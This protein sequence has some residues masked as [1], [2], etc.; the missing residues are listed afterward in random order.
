MSPEFYQ[1]QIGKNQLRADVPDG[2][3]LIANSLRYNNVL[4]LTQLPHLIALYQQ[5]EKTKSMGAK[6]Q[7]KHIRQ[8]IQI[9]R[10]SETPPLIVSQSFLAMVRYGLSVRK[11]DPGEFV[12]NYRQSAPTLNELNTWNLTYYD[13]QKAKEAPPILAGTVVPIHLD[14]IDEN[15]VWLRPVTDGPYKG[16]WTVGGGHYDNL[17]EVAGFE[18]LREET[19]DSL[20]HYG[21]LP[22]C[23][24]DQVIGV[25]QGNN[26]V[27]RHYLNFV[28]W[29]P[30]APRDYKPKTE[31]LNRPWSSFADDEVRHLQLTPLAQ[32][33]LKQTRIFI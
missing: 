30:Y 10:G 16:R 25:S 1:Y 31:N 3:M 15:H 12:R 13:V 11:V 22:L 7:L 23:L 21:C 28:W 32:I 4:S 20:S 27:L 14:G 19:G 8:A 33:S 29:N 17:N 18:E 24:A 9:L 6:T 26:V 5:A 2:P